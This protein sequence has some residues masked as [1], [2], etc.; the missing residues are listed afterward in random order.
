MNTARPIR[1]LLFVWGIF[2]LA[3]AAF[4]A[5]DAT[6]AR[7]TDGA[8][9]LLGG[10]QIRVFATVPGGPAEQQGIQ[11][12]DIVEAIGGLPIRDPR[13]AARLLQS[14][15][16]G[17]DV[18]YLVRRDRRIY[19]V[20]IRL[21]STRLTDVRTYL[22]YC[23]LGLVYF[24]AG[25]WIVWRNRRLE[26]ARLFYIL[27]S[28]FLI[29]FFSA[30]DRSTIYYWSDLFVRNVG[31]FASLMV[32]PLFLHFFLVFPERRRVMD[33]FPWLLPLI[34]ALPLAFYLQFS[35]E[36]FFGLRE[37]TVGAVEQMTL[38]I[39]FTAGLASLVSIY[40]GSHDPTLRQRV[41][42]LT[43]G[44]VLGTLPFL[45]FNIALGKLLGRSDLALLGAVP[46]VLVPVSFGY[47]IA[48]YRLMDIEVIIRRS[49]IY[50]VLTGAVVGSYLV[51]VVVVGNL[52]LDVSGQQSQLVAIISTLIIAAAFQP[53]RERIQSFLERR[54]FREKHDLQ[55]AL[56]ELSREIP[57]SLDREGLLDLVDL[58]IRSLLHPL[59]L[60]FVET[61]DGNLCIP[62][63]QS[64]LVMPWLSS[65][66]HRRRGP[67]TPE[68]M[69]AERERKT[70]NLISEQRDLEFVRLTAADLEV[71]V[72]AFAGDRLVGGLALGP[73]RS[74]VA[75]DGLELDL[76]TTVAGQLAVQ[77]ENIRLYT[78]E[79]QRQK[80]EEELSVARSIQ[81]R[82][83]PSRV[84][85]LAGFELARL[86]IASAQVS[87]DYYDFVEMD[88]RCG[89]VIADVSGKG[90]PASLLASNL[91]ASIRALA[92]FRSEPAEIFSAVNKTLYES[93]DPERFATAFLACLDPVNGEIRY[94][95]AGHNYP[96]LRRFDGRIEELSTGA[97]PL[98]AFPEIQ[99]TE[100]CV[101][102]EPGDVLVLYT[103]GVTE[104]EDAQGEQ[105]GEE[106]LERLIHDCPDCTAEDLVNRIQQAVDGHGDGSAG[107]DM[108]LIVV[109]RLPLIMEPSTGTPT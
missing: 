31:T 106:G 41:K 54:F 89:M 3:I 57:T 103:D 17:E 44:T 2:A 49:L 39:Y 83:L 13:H 72:P 97:T 7:P 5:Y 55:E 105:F 33:R 59:T 29:Y 74:E 40:V 34:Y 47:S 18:L 80:F 27:C 43:M 12:G 35:W 26:A 69:Q 70:S 32:P 92:T 58:R 4:S 28:L 82:L 16:V 63:G 38:G 96:L 23:A 61:E 30:S 78:E 87:G 9:W 86:N 104:T 19:E 52:V 46:M 45:V 6:R 66:V 71:F 11:A 101:S 109:R 56:A 48:R 68:L 90:L 73:K 65:V 60:H 108:T 98:G 102:L 84:P 77:L 22:V 37:A 75:Y 81:Q 50:A 51:L 53:A 88:A 36:Q 20:S 107:D 91:Q 21:G 62:D 8:Y 14:K 67:I 76:L 64:T 100:D 94:A 10:D 93:T 95:N 25:A 79:V 15:Q 99:Y 42:F 24:I 85:N 1:Q